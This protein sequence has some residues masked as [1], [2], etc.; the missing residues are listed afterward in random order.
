MSR[1]PSTLPALDELGELARDRVDTRLER[2]LGEHDR[3][4]AARIVSI[5]CRARTRTV[6]RPVR[7]ASLMPSSPMMSPPVGKSGPFTMRISSLER[8]VGLVDQLQR[9]VA[10]LGRGC[11]AGCWWPCP[12]AIPCAPFTSRLGNR[13]R[14]HDRLRAGRR[15]S[16]APESTVPSS[17]PGEQLHRELRQPALRVAA[18]RRRVGRRTEVAVLVDERSRERERLAHAHERVV[19][20]GV[21]VRVVVGHHV[22]D[23]TRALHERAI[24]AQ[25]RVVHRPEDAAV[26][27]L[28]AVANVGQRARSRS[29]SSSTRGTRPRPPRRACGS[30]RS[31]P[32]RV[33]RQLV[34]SAGR[35]FLRGMPMLPGHER[36]YTSRNRTSLALC[37]IQLR[38]ASTSSPISTDRSCRRRSRS[39]VDVELHEMAASRD[40]CTSRAARA[41]PSRP[42]P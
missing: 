20:R 16:W 14:Q 9:R 23:D 22:A 38:R 42:D 32:R 13:A 40:P 39:L 6:P 5:S 11:A 28:Q 27:G 26:H 31:P 18:R 1:T 17:M 7:N 33:E 21:A 37:W 24:G 2:H 15:R 12:T 4:T 34:R 19:D 36:S 25:V 35:G 41:G 29:R 3:L 30:A 10:D 8:R